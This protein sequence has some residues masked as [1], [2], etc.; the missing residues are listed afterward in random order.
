[1]MI[2]STKNPK[3]QWIRRLQS[4]GQQRQ[5]EGLFVVEGV[6]LVEVARS[7]DWE[8][9]FLVYTEELSSRG[10]AIVEESAKYNTQTT[11]IS[12]H[13]MRALSDTKNPQGILA[14]IKMKSLPVPDQLDF[15]LVLDQVREPGNLGAILRSASAAGV[16][17][18]CLTAGTVDPYSPKVLRA[19]MGAQLNLPVVINTWEEVK[20]LIE[21]SK[22]KTF[23]AE[24]DKGELYHQC[25]FSQP[26]ALIIGGE[27][28]GAGE[29]AHRMADSL[30]HIPM[31]GGG[32]SL[33]ASVS[34]GIILFEV[35]RQRGIS[36]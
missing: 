7:S 24:A 1:M 23:I 35:V 11:K 4:K 12:S 34:A 21:T 9:E 33:N 6:R 15:V 10:M 16:Q 30:I 31:P 8:I 14:V 3:A 28:E 20:S 36:I 5:V 13:V 2:S 17:V 26:L 32:E 22:L 18:V 29:K 19:G 27:A 25:D